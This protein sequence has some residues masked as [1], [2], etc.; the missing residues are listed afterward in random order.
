VA[1][2][3]PALTGWL[4]LLPALLQVGPLRPLLPQ[5]L[6]QHQQQGKQAEV[7]C[8]RPEAYPGMTS[9]EARQQLLLLVLLLE[10]LLLPA[11]GVSPHQVLPVQ[12]LPAAAA[13]PAG[14]RVLPQVGQ[15]QARA[16]R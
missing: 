4:L 11:A 12:L 16:V 13:E 8:P 3:G 15:Q 9:W 1:R 2:Q 6:Q 10:V 7:G 14:S 5:V